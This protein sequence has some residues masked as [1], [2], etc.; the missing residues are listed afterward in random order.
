MTDA[1]AA[2]ALPE[3]ILHFARALRDA[4]LPV[5]PGAVLDAVAAIEATGFTH[6]QDFRAA[7]HAVFVKKHEHTLLFDQ[8]FDIYWKRKGF[9]EK[10]IAMM[11]PQAKPETKAKK[12]E[13]GASRVAD[14]L[15][16][17]AP[18][19]DEKREPSL[20]LDARLTMSAAEI[21][22]TRD[23]AQMSAAEIALARQIIAKLVMPEDRRRTRRFAPDRLGARIDP[24]RSFRGSLKGVIDLQFRAPLRKPPPIVALCDI[25][26]SMAEYTRLFLHFL[27]AV[28][29]T[30]RVSTF[31]FG[32]RL[33]NVTRALRRRD[34]DE[35]LAACAADVKDWS[36]G[37]RIAASLHA[38]NRDWS[39][40]VLGQGAIVLLFTDGLERDGLDGLANEMQRLHMSSRR[41]IWLNPLLRFDG[42]AAKAQGMRAMLPHVDEFRAIHS[43]ASMAE[44]VRALGGDAGRADP[45]AWL[46]AG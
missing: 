9:L 18:R 37:T 38:F 10:L 6:K 8:V 17:N 13:A 11:S 14:A 35:A 39:R 44:L 25:S 34:P 31:L 12:A 21:L 36:G 1:P 30:R 41:L 45:K 19:Q 15:F 3:N 7:L 5:G 27:H 4:G 46:R 32:T 40:R 33:T 26:G 29:E 24:R 16:K 42:F 28:G 20:E 23:F 43:L 2:G 22:Q